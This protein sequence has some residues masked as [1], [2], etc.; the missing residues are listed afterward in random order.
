M[1]PRNFE[2]RQFGDEHQAESLMQWCES[3]RVWSPGI[4]AGDWIIRSADGT[5]RV[6]KPGSQDGYCA[7]CGLPVWWQDDWLVA[8]RGGRWCYG[9]D[10]SH[11]GR[12][13]WHA[14]PGM[15]QY[16]A[17]AAEGQVCHCLD[18]DE[19]H[20]HQIVPVAGQAG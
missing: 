2:A 16:I 18:R 20:I 19:P 17:Q 15:H 10:D 14:L 11:S 9:R 4:Q 6:D 3:L 13:R 8:K 5:V 12:T 1:I 7:D